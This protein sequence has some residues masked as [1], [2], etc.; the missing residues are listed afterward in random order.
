S[1]GNQG[2]DTP[3]EF[4]ASSHYVVAVGAVDGSDVAA[5]FTSYGDFV[6]LCAPGVLVRSLFPTSGYALWSGTSMSAGFVSGGFALPIPLHPDWTEKKLLDRLTA[7]THRI[8]QVGYHSGLGA[9]ALDLGAA[10]AP[11]LLSTQ[12]DEQPDH[13]YTN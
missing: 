5:P 7:T 4:P 1:A 6:E 11:E 12:Q 3:V 8:S 9:G 13:H 2:S 10:L